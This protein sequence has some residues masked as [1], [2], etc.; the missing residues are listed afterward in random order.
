MD[1]NVTVRVPAAEKLIDYTASGI[2]SIAGSMLASWQARQEVNA[3]L[4]HAEGEAATLRLIAEA[5]SEARAMLLAPEAATQGELT[6]AETVRQRI[7]F[8]EEKR[9]RNIASVV[10]Q[11][12]ESL[13]DR[14]V[15]EH[16][17]NHDW[18]ARF[19]NEVQDISSEEMQTLWSKVLAGE[20]ERPG[21]TAIHTLD[22]LR[23]L[24]QRAAQLFKT[25]C[26]LSLAFRVDPNEVVD[27][28][29]LSLGKNAGDNSLEAFGLGFAELNVLNEHGL[30]ISDYNSWRDYSISVVPGRPENSGLVIPL[31]LHGDFWVLMPKVVQQKPARL[32]LHGVALTRAGKELSWAVTPTTN[33][34]YAEALVKF[35]LSKGLQLQQVGSWEPQAVAVTSA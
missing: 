13:G 24:D 19:F 5:Q 27:S 25:L 12:A 29:V 9:Q 30:I 26:S 22:I 14:E 16:E 7:E 28:R 35:L 31:M 21:S 8:Q 17:P 2:G 34:A 6:I 32:K 4:I 11:A 18:T 3:R 33:N 23:N 1:L 20:V 10:T 15:P